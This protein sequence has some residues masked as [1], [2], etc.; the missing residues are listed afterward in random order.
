MNKQSF[1]EYL[2]E[3]TK[4]KA[5]SSK[6]FFS[7]SKNKTSTKK[8]EIFDYALA[9]GLIFFSF[10]FFE[11]IPVTISML[12]LGG[13]FASRAGLR[14]RYRRFKEENKNKQPK[15]VDIKNL[16][17]STQANINRV[18]KYKVTTA[19]LD[20]QKKETAKYQSRYKKGKIGMIASTA[21]SLLVPAT[22]PV[23]AAIPALINIG[24][25]IYERHNAKKLSISL[26]KEEKYRQEKINLKNELKA[27]K[28]AQNKAKQT[29]SF[30]SNKTN[31]N[32]TSRQ[33]TPQANNQNTAQTS[34]QNNTFKNTQNRTS[35]SDEYN[36]LINKLRLINQ[37]IESIKNHQKSLYIKYQQLYKMYQNAKAQG[38]KSQEDS[39][40]QLLYSIKQQIDKMD[41]ELNQLNNQSK[42]TINILLNNSNSKE[43]EK[44]KTI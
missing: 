26:D 9:A 37:K 34:K 17:I 11:F 36:N 27:V 6:S 44:P 28:Q 16:D 35:T 20:K 18:K 41:L 29:N 42:N 7:N 39:Y 10:G 31:I 12:T 13:F 5:K 1:L 4:N 38:N 14:G 19:S 33:N 2:A 8:K 40:L 43:K 15:Q 3:K 22:I 32:Q 21:A 24:L 25:F 30:S 23:V